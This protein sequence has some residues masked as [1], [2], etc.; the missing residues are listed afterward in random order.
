[1]TELSPATLQNIPLSYASCSI[2][3]K[4]EH[5]LPQKLDAIAAAG[6][7]GIELS[8]PDLLSFASVHLRHEVGPKDFDDL[9][10][11]AKAVKAMCDAKNLQIMMLQ[12]F[13]NFEGWAEGSEERRD[14]FERAKGWIRIMEACGTDMLQVRLNNFQQSFEYPAH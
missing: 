4:P 1:M 7:T 11:A 5:T 3:C 2:G 8:M 9:C 6:F 10:T 12:P 14:A 13:A